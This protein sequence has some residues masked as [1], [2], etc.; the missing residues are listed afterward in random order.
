MRLRRPA[1]DYRGGKMGIAIKVVLLFMVIAAITTLIGGCAAPHARKDKDL[2]LAYAQR[3]GHYFADRGYDM[4]DVVTAT[5]EFPVFGAAV[6]AGPGKIG[7]MTSSH[8]KATGMGGIGIGV[9][10]ET[11]LSG[12]GLRCGQVGT[13]TQEEMV[14]GAAWDRPPVYD[15]ETRASV[16]GKTELREKG[17]KANPSQYARI[18]IAAGLLVGIRFELNFGELADFMLGIVG[19]DLMNDDM[20]HKLRGAKR[21][22]LS[23]AGFAALPPK[24]G[25]FS[26]LISLDLSG[27]QLEELPP[28]LVQLKGLQTLDLS[29]NRFRQLPPELAGFDRIEQLTLDNNRLEKTLSPEIGTLSSLT[30]LSIGNNQLEAL[31]EEIGRLQKLYD[32]RLEN[33]RIERLPAGLGNL[34][35]LHQLSLAKNRIVSVPPDLGKL[36]YLEELNLQDNQLRDL[37]ADLSRLP[38]LRALDLSRNPLDKIPSVVFDMEGLVKLSL[39]GI[40]LQE[41]PKEIMRLQ[42]LRDLR[43]NNNRLKTVPVDV[44]AKLPLEYLSLDGNQLSC[45]EMRRLDKAFR[46]RINLGG[47]F[48]DCH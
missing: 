25:D 17:P 45:D 13:Y 37:P 31:P 8:P 10:S 42:Y 16:R 21:L 1:G 9:R 6:I 44:L 7:L 38:A 32:L 48:S 29:G 40:G 26:D 35:S 34:Q 4:L 20:A 36:P 39:D 5:I 41:L 19:I 47:A 33:N 23:N 30:R 2:F 18:G 3:D 22:N 43:L 46:N 12:F 27:N 15:G 11:R 28:T 14:L 24:I